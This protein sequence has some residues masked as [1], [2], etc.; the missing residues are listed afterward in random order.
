M[1][2][3][4][5][6]FAVSA[7]LTVFTAVLISPTSNSQTMVLP[8]TFD[9]NKQ[10][11]AVYTVPIS[12]A[13][14]TSGMEPE[15]S[16][17]YNSSS[18][19]GVVGIGW[20]LTG[21]SSIYR[22]VPLYPI[23]EQVPAVTNDHS[24]SFC[25]DGQELLLVSGER[26]ADLSEYR[27]E[28]EG[29]TKVI[30]HGVA[31]NGPAYFEAI[32]KTGQVME[33]GRADS[34]RSYAADGETIQ[35]WNVNRISD[36]VGNYLTVSYVA[37]PDGGQLYPERVNYTGNEAAG[38]QPYNSVRFEY[39]ERHDPLLHMQSGRQKMSSL[40]LVKIESYSNDSPVF[41]YKLQYAQ[42]QEIPN[43]AVFRSTLTEIVLCSGGATICLPATSFDYSKFA[44]PI[45]QQESAEDIINPTEFY[46]YDFH[47]GTGA[48]IPNVYSGDWNGDGLKDFLIY[49]ER[50]GKNI[51]Y[52]NKG[53]LQF[54]RLEDI[55]DPAEIQ[56]V[57][58]FPGLSLGWPKYSFLLLDWNGDN[59]VDVLFYSPYE[60]GRN[61]WYINNGDMTFRA[62]ENP[63]QFTSAHWEWW[64]P[65]DGN[66]EPA[67]FGDAHVGDYN[68]DGLPD[69]MF[70]FA[71]TG[72]NFWFINQTDFGATDSA[73]DDEVVFS[74]FAF[75]PVDPDSIKRFSCNGTCWWR[76]ML[77]DFNVDGR[78]D[79]AWRLQGG[80]RQ[81]APLYVFAGR[82]DGTFEDIG[83]TETLFLNEDDLRVVDINAD[84]APDFFR[85]RS[86]F[87]G[88]YHPNIHL[89]VNDG[90]G[91][92]SA[93]ELFWPLP[94]LHGMS[95]GNWTG[96][97]HL[98]FIAFDSNTGDNYTYRNLGNGKYSAPIAN[99]Y[100]RTYFRRR[101]ST[102]G[103]VPVPSDLNGDGIDD[104]MI[105]DPQDGKNVWYVADLVKSELLTEITTGLGAQTQI[106]YRALSDASVY[107]INDTTAYPYMSWTG[108]MYV[109]SEVNAEVGANEF[110]NTT[111]RYEDAVMELQGRGMQ[112]FAKV[113]VMDNERD[114]TQVQ[115]FR[116]DFPFSG[117]LE[118]EEQWLGGEQGQLIS[119][120]IRSYDVISYDGT[121]YFPFLSES[122]DES[123]D[124]DGTALPTSLTTYEYDEFGNSTLVVVTNSDGTKRTTMNT[125]LNDTV[126]W[127]LGRLTSTTVV[128]EIPDETPN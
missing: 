61:V 22:C 84:S 5:C 79:V 49:E 75:N 58:A 18:G 47:S 2:F 112:G 8:G 76:P 28:M 6:R 120:N 74:E 66:V 101:Y 121:R 62:I 59:Q 111:Y 37:E 77:A 71:I 91:Q 81:A 23:P 29:F 65:V 80:H 128:N 99:R 109:V 127:H 104:L 72:S 48:W 107:T 19:N 67:A 31:G 87:Y 82:G 64:T 53:N 85:R 89:Y 10:G 88:G 14:G 52:V 125:Y 86:N 3:I 63:I 124:L 13:P 1:K 68:R 94:S 36:V 108:P 11:G 90:T 15:I 39:E 119:R 43:Q 42:S 51:W 117:L 96:S 103:A 98:D 106:T 95:I 24:D 34:T 60:N 33:F 69:I 115:R 92:F 32:T 97:G 50:T 93:S 4:R 123:F 17:E 45:F 38:L 73:A 83:P 9:V 122:F 70:H 114:I 46:D 12:I 100:P 126:N 105:W 27:T 25:I 35:T 26:G 116:T 44:L 110:Y 57:D 21:F 54:D 16:L 30:A 7:W 55:I 113:F 102:G 78:I 40:R 20:M 56:E 118:T 41:E